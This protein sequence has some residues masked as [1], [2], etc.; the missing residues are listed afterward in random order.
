MELRKTV[1]VKETI[2]ADDLGQACTPIVRVAALAVIRNPFAGKQ[3]AFTNQ[4]GLGARH[5][6]QNCAIER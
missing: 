1:I 6:Y 2:E 4:I 3:A 5:N